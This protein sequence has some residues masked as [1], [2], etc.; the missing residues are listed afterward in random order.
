[1]KPIAMSYSTSK[2]IFTKFFTIV[3]LAGSWF[4]S[5]PTTNINLLSIIDNLP[6]QQFPL[7]IWNGFAI[8][9]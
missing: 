1:M 5:G 3:M 2:T 4:S 7:V 8:Q 6:L 9:K